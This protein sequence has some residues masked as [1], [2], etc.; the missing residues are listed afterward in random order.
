MADFFW[1]F[2]LYSFVGFLFEVVYA[3]ATHSP[4]QDRKCLYLLPLCPVYGLGAVL[5]LLLPS[6]VRDNPLLLLP[7]AAVLCTAAEYLMGLFYEKAARVP[8]WDYS[9]LPCSL[10]GR[11]CL[12]FTLYWGALS[13]PALYIIHPAAAWLAARLPLWALPPAALVLGADTLLT[14]LV[15]RRTGDTDSLRWYARLPRRRAA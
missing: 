7:A 2:F 11:V 6:A 13:L 9:H 8:F 5:I 1:Y 14:A 15:L 12:R 3:R 10:G 4:K